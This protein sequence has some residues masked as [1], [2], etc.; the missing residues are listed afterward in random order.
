MLR[1]TFYSW[2]MFKD[3]QLNFKKKK[4]RKK[5]MKSSREKFFFL[6]FWRRDKEI[7]NYV[8]TS[9]NMQEKQL[10]KLRVDPKEE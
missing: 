8:N 5:N 6:P 4:K 1:E 9:R 7:E 2:K 10:L 3:I